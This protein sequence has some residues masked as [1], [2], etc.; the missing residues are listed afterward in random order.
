M[1]WNQ[2]IELSFSCTFS[3]FDF[4]IFPRKA[5]VK[6]QHSK[7]SEEEHFFNY[8]SNDPAHCLKKMLDVGAHQKSKRLR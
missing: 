8:K 2:Q 7:N 4:Q 1:K 5:N 3:D 6:I